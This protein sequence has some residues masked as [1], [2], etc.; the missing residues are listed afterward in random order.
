MSFSRSMTS[1]ERSGRTFTTIMWMEFVPMSMAARRMQKSGNG[2]EG[3]GGGTDGPRHTAV[4]Y[5]VKASSRPMSPTSPN[6]RHPTTIRPKPS[7]TTVLL[8]RRARE[9]ERHLPAAV[10]G[11][12]VAVHQARVASRRLREAVPVL[13]ADTKIR[14]KAERKIQGHAG[15]GHGP[16]DGR[17][18]R[19]WTSLRAVQIPRDALEDVRGHV[20]AERDR[21]SRCSTGCA[22]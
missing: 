4:I 5:C 2:R 8:L 15:A 14:K 20:I 17:P 10:A 16:G 9:L 11:D 13:A 18:C 3:G 1:N 21:R 12:D 19:F 22:A 6:G 7:V